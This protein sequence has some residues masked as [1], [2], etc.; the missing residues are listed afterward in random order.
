MRRD[1]TWHGNKL[2]FDALPPNSLDFF[3]RTSPTP[4]LLQSL[5]VDI[6]SLARGEGLNGT[7]TLPWHLSL[8]FDSARTIQ[9]SALVARE[10]RRQGLGWTM[11]TGAGVRTQLLRRLFWASERGVAGEEGEEQGE[12]VGD[13]V[14]CACSS[15]EEESTEESASAE[16]G[17]NG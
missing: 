13:E 17:G 14:G 3:L 5:S 9:A 15:E 10:F 7:N 12:G 4:A 11:T 16:N 8:A 2:G 6:T 1:G